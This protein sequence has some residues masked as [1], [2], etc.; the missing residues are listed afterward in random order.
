VK[1]RPCA[2]II[3]S[4][5]YTKLLPDDGQSKRPKYVIQILRTYCIL[6]SCVFSEHKEMNLVYNYLMSKGPWYLHQQII[7]QWTQC[8]GGGG[9]R[10]IGE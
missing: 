6:I 4:L 8:W 3:F 2:E 9:R 5:M 10:G 7:E 1:K